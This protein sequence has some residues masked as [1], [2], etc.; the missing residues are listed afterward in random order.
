MGKVTITDLAKTCGVSKA[1]V[2]RVLNHPEM[3]SEPLRNRIR[4]TMAKLGYTPNPFARTLGTGGSHG[5]GLFVLDIL[6]PFFGLVAREINKLAF[7]RGIPLTVCDSDYNAEMEMVYLDHVIQNHIGGIIFTE[8][9]SERAVDMAE[10]K[11]PMVLI[12][13]HYEDRLLPEVTSDNFGGAFAATEY[14]IQLNHKR[15]GFVTGP[16]EWSTAL[17]RFRGYQAA[18][19]KHG[20]PFD[21]GL[22][23]HGDFRPESGME[24]IDYFF[25][26]A[27][28]PTAVFCS[29]DQMVFGALNKAQVLN[30]SIPQD[31]SLVG[32]DDIPLVSLVRPKITTVRQDVPVLCRKAMDLLD[33]QIR[34][35]SRQDRVVVPTQFMARETC[36]KTSMHPTVETVSRLRAEDTG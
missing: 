11:V 6:N 19:E 10:G 24:A 7:E 17:H 13:L 36:K 3:V 16:L 32:F 35:E 5:I 31:F 30:L 34:G 21:P 33:G 15:I 29:N 2:S 28:W 20:I 25:S 22:V 18:L 26:R 8:G 14:L 4:E 12:D 23:Y 1:T 9:I 27:E